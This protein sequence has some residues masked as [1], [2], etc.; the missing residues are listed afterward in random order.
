MK[1]MKKVIA[2]LLAVLMIVSVVPTNSIVA[3]AASKTATVTTQSKL[4]TALKKKSIT[5]INVKT[6]KKSKFS[7]K[8]KK[9]KTKT[10]N[11]NGSKITFKNSGVFKRINIAN[12]STFTENASGNILNVTDSKATI[13]IGKNAKK[14]TVNL[15]K[16]GANITMKVN[17]S[18]SSVNVKKAST[19][20]VTGKPKATL[21][22]TNEAAGSKLYIDT[23]SKISLA[24]KNTSTLTVGKNVKDATI[25]LS[26]GITAKI[27]NNSKK[28]ITVK[29]TGNT[30][31]VV[32]AG[33]TE[34]VSNKVVAS[35]EAFT[36]SF[37]TNGGSIVENQ[38]VEKGKKILKPEDP[39]WAGF[40]FSGWYYDDSFKHAYDFNTAVSK[41]L[42]LYA[43]WKIIDDS[44]ITHTVTFVLNDGSVG[45]YELQTVNNNDCAVRPATDPSR[46]G[47]EFTGWYD[48]ATL[49][50]KF[51]FSSP[52][53]GD[54]T[55]Y[56]GWGNPD[57]GNGLYDSQSGGETTY[58]VSSLS[59]EGDTVKSTVNAN[60]SCILVISFY[61]ETGY[62][63]KENNNWSIDSAHNYGNLSTY[64]PDYCEATTISLDI[65]SDIELPEYYIVTG[66][67]YDSEDLTP[68]CAT[69][70]CSDYTKANADF[71]A[72]TI[73]DFDEETV[74]NFD[75]RDDNNFGV[76][77]EDIIEI[78]CNDTSNVL[79]EDITD[80][81]KSD[82]EL[83][84]QSTYT[85]SNPDATVAALKEGDKIVIYNNGTAENVLKVESITKDSE[86]NISV[87][88]SLDTELTDF[89]SVLKVEWITSDKED[90]NREENSESEITTQAELIDA[91]V[92]P[93]ASIATSLEWKINQNAK[94]SGELK[95]TA[96]LTVKIKY[97]AKLFRKD[98][99]ECSVKS[100]LT[101]TL[102]IKLEGSIDNGE[103]VKKK[104]E[105]VKV[106]FKTPIVGLDAYTA[107]TF[108]TEVG[109]SGG[110][111]I[112]LKFDM[113]NGFNYNSNSGRE[114]IEK[115]SYSVDF[116][117]EA[118]F[119]VKTGPK[120]TLGVTFAKDKID[121][122]IDAQI[123]IKITA[124]LSVTQDDGI[125]TN[126]DSKHSCYTCL[127]GK[128]RWFAT[129]SIKLNYKI[130]K[131]VLEGTAF[132]L[133]V[134]NVEGY[135]H[136]GG[137][138]YLSLLNSSESIF[139]GKIKFG[140]GDCPN[141]KYRTTIETYN[142]DGDKVTGIS[143]TITKNNGD[144]AKSGKSD[145]NT[146]LYDGVY[147]VSGTIDNTA[148]S[149]S[150]V[151]SGDKKTVK[152]TVSSNSTTKITGN[153]RDAET[154]NWIS[155]ATIQFKKGNMTIAT[156][157]S[158]SDGSFSA[159]VPADSYEIVIS[160]DGYVTV[161][162]NET[163]VENE[164]KY[165]ATTDLVPGDDNGKGGFGGYITDALTG[166]AVGDVILDVRE[167]ANSPDTNDILLTLKTDSAGHYIYNPDSFFGIKRG[168]PSGQYTIT[169]QKEG[170][171]TTSFN[172]I[173]KDDELV[174]GQNATISPVLEEN[175]FR[176]VLRWGRS[177][178]D[179]D[180][181]YNA[182]GESDHVYYSN[183]TGS[184]ANLD[185]D[186]TSSYG[187]ETITVT[188][189]SSL[190]SGFVYSVHD[191]SNRN[192]SSSSALS[193]SGA[194][195]TVYHG[196]NSPV[197][198]YVPVGYVGTVWNVFRVDDSGNIEALNTFENCSSPENVGSAL[199]TY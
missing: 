196:D 59:V 89:Y 130:I 67:L 162:T 15:N 5:S 104:L 12:V 112:T 49:T 80:V 38:T 152:L 21:N 24:L 46:A 3:Q 1:K 63:G 128:A 179:L 195:V 30:S 192:S 83:I 87:T 86:D 7:V 25:T 147:K 148:V 76:L 127:S 150:F 171:I 191:Y 13:E 134:L 184:T 190:T 114:D 131:D 181:H 133:T 34:S 159:D 189:F 183:K 75:N 64:T 102:E 68:L 139:G 149:N 99:F 92:S 88:E 165:M 19:L 94:L 185:V 166:K 74:L 164:T 186:D 9:Y 90:E 55:I 56:A 110:V 156:V 47:Y 118:K 50:S 41:N 119:E 143:V 180:S 103:S 142:T 51:D 98:Y 18:V 126:V 111:S 23:S 66:T 39:T 100:N 40:T 4:N 26:K 22:L 177:P 33:K 155:D 61:D 135:I 73:N 157:Q 113:T 106:P 52:I 193:N 144:V 60:E 58:S 6:K 16:K 117:G 163:V 14:T 194:C 78:Y 160:K 182:I 197:I 10:L 175:E 137:D 124:E 43:K 116:K 141:E 95:G 161:T 168:L 173:V 97:D 27:V 36:I 45:A 123:G 37:D 8:S 122:S 125:A 120:F 17:G 121:S 188:K 31:V 153:V 132:D 72:L 169:A 44:D 146:Y 176:I 108:P 48:D 105:G 2:V 199:T 69:Y 158:G 91:E 138:F 62:F 77:V 81:E 154:Q 35:V 115:K 129:V 53:T 42:T 170:Y 57:G 29:R 140:W 151:I 136:G 198:F 65:G 71:E 79:T 28:S 167:G 107:V 84:Q 82:G 54:I 32:K 109:F 101:G 172:I 187:P 174:E 145:L 178:S 20:K 93:S 11:I 70:I 85:F 96:K